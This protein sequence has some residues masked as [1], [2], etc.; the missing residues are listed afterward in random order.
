M[1]SSVWGFVIAT[2]V[3]GGMLFIIS[4][5]FM[6]WLR[7]YFTGSRISLLSLM[8]MSLRKINPGDIV[9]CKVMAVQ[10]GLADFPTKAIEAQYLAG[11]NVLSI[12]RALVAAHRA[13]IT[14]DWNTAAAIDLAGRDILEAVQVSVTPKVIYCPD[15]ESKQGDT[16]SAVAKDGIQLQVRALVTVRTNLLQL[17]GGATEPTIIA[18]VGEGIVSA[19]GSCNTY[20]EILA[21][22][23]L[24]SQKVMESE[25]ASQ[26]A[27]TIVSIDIADIDVGINIGA[28]IQMDQAV[29]DIKIARAHAEKRRAMANARNQEMLALTKRNQALVVLA[30]AEIPLAVAIAFRKGQLRSNYKS[31]C[32]TIPIGQYLQKT[33]QKNRMNPNADQLMNSSKLEEWEA[34]GGYC[35]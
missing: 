2:V 3:L 16:L 19:I 9:H 24:I 29:A 17:I 1:A 22:P 26:T 35:G 5:Y 33:Q 11:G 14:L 8:L 6:L 20:R 23:L 4:H 27:F 13:E 7:A 25:L 15:Q 18:R 31:E 34:E 21:N 28:R 12:T 30:E 10:A 32:R